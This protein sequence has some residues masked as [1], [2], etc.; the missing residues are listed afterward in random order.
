[1]ARRPGE[2]ASSRHPGGDAHVGKHGGVGDRSRRKSVPAPAGLAEAL[3]GDAPAAEHALQDRPRSRAARRER[4]PDVARDRE[5][6]PLDLRDVGRRRPG[7]PLEI[8]Q[9]PRNCLPALLLGREHGQEHVGRPPALDGLEQVAGG[10][11][12]L[13]P[14]AEQTHARVRLGPWCCRHR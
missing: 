2:P 8:G 11:L 14:L 7:P 5:Q 9:R 4:A 3:A 1:V 13:G 6:T 10:G 12:H